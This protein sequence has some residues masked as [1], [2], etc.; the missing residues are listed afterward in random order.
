MTLATDSTI[1]YFWVGCSIDVLNG[2]SAFNASQGKSCW[3][4]FFV[5][6]NGNTAMLE[7]QRRFNPLV[8]WWSTFQLIHYQMPTGCCHNSN[9]IVHVS[10]VSTL[11]QIYGQCGLLLAQVPEFQ[12]LVPRSGHQ[13]AVIVWFDPMTSFH[14]CIML[15]NLCS[16]KKK[17]KS[18]QTD[19]V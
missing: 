9:R 15:G 10:T 1:N 5:L 17:R 13:T 19:Q 2:N 8:L 7:L 14:W 18:Y 11:W 3:H 16:F 6:E 12:S 4:S